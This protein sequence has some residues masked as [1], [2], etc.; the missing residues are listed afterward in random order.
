[1]QKLVKKVLTMISRPVPFITRSIRDA[2]VA[3]GR[4]IV[5]I[6]LSVSYSL[7]QPLS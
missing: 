3:A 1:M 5:N 6:T 4:A 2:I 7:H